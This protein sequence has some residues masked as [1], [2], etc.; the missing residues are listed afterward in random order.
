TKK[1]VVS[2]SLANNVPV[3]SLHSV[4][5]VE[6][7]PETNIIGAAR[8]SSR[9]GVLFFVRVIGDEIEKGYLSSFNLNVGKF[10]FGNLSKPQV[11]ISYKNEG[12]T[13]LNP[14]GF[15]EVLN[16]FGQTK[17]SVKISP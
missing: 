13:Y 7:K 2:A 10:Q 11:F 12:N 5:F 17:K 14:Y 6:A 9:V 1:I 8:V 16:I 4:L 3:G 15:L